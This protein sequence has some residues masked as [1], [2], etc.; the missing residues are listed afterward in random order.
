MPS[1]GRAYVLPASLMISRVGRRS[2]G[3]SRRC[4]HGPSRRRCMRVSRVRL[5][6]RASPRGF[7]RRSIHDESC[8]AVTDMAT[9][10]CPHSLDRTTASTR[11]GSSCH[12]RP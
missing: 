9:R 12:L 10:G 2:H 8:R 7:L 1:D 4:P 11:D 5:H 6:Q 3:P